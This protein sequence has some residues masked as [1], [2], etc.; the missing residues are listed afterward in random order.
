MIKLEKKDV[1]FDLVSQEMKDVAATIINK[2][3]LE[4]AIHE[5]YPLSEDELSQAKQIV[6]TYEFAIVDLWNY[7][8]DTSEANEDNRK[9]FAVLCRECFSLLKTLPIPINDL[10]KMKFVLKLLTFAYLGEKWE[11][12]GRFM[13]ENKSI[14]WDIRADQTEWD[15]RLFST[16]YLAILHLTR[17]E[18]WDD[19]SAAVRLIQQ[20]RTQQKEFEATYLETTKSEEKQGSAL[21]FSFAL[22]LGKISGAHYGVYAAGQ[23]Q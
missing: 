14:V 15:Y 22:S 8:F 16:L 4:R 17:K 2:S 7:A 18:S 12:M 6:E 5:K 21:E 10:E 20:L 13:R 1:P 11:D 19:L 3:N 9:K 23:S